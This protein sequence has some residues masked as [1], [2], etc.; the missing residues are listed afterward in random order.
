MYKEYLVIISGA[1]QSVPYLIMRMWLG[2][3]EESF[4]ALI[5]KLGVINLNFGIIITNLIITYLIKIINLIISL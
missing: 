5:M 2:I 3:Q 1:Y 4:N